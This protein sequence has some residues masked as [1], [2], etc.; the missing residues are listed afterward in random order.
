[1]QEC[2]ITKF[3]CCCARFE[4]L[5][6]NIFELNVELPELYFIPL[7]IYNRC[8]KGIFMHVS[9]TVFCAIQNLSED[10]LGCHVRMLPLVPYFSFCCTSKLMFAAS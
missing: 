9:D 6:C 1:V 10:F 5:V 3:W 4:A 7:H 8:N 2:P